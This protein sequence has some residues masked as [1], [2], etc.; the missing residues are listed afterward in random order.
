MLTNFELIDLCKKYHIP[1]RGVY[2]KDQLPM[3]LKNGNYIINLQ[4][5]NGGKNHGT[6]FTALIVEGFNA[7]YFDSFGAPCPLEVRRFVQ[8]RK[9]IHLGFNN[10]IIQDLHSQKCGWFCLGFLLNNERSL[11][12]NLYE[13]ANDYVNIFDDDDNTNKNDD[14]LMKLFHS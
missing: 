10:W 8:K 7:C 5:S 11:K 6:H 1:L 4:S 2:M 14:I 13:K 3:H 12:S 9:G